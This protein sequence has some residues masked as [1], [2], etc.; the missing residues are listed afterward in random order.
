MNRIEYNRAQAIHHH[1]AKLNMQYS[2]QDEFGL[3]KL[4][5]DFKLFKRGRRKKISHILSNRSDFEKQKFIFDYE[6]VR[7]KNNSRKYY[8][9]TVLFLNSKHLGLPQFS[10]APEQLWHKLA[11]WLKIKSDI[12]FVNHNEFSEN[13]FLEGED[14]DI[15]R[16]IFNEDVLHFFSLHKNWHLEGLNYFLILY[17]HNERFHP[18]ILPGFYKMG[19]KLHDLFETH[20]E[21]M[22]LDHPL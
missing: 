5:K 17:S 1:G 6:Y 14:E 19:M 18:D 22:S 8:R 12:D 15:I 11:N 9:Q 10:M 3:I 2:A 21:A 4:L 20:P 7:G 16:Y 13:Y